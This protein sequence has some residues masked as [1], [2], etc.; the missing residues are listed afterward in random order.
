MAEFGEPRL[1]S[2]VRLVR[3]VDQHG[4]PR[5]LWNEG[6]QELELLPDETFGHHCREPAHIATRMR[7][8]L[9]EADRDRV[10]HSDENERNCR[11]TDVDRDRVWRS[12]SDDDLWAKRD[13][14]SH[15][16]WDLLVPALRVTILDLEIST[17]DIAAVA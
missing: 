5:R 1:I 10:A 4:D 17:H 12:V 8:A 11:S 6:L 14:L 7:Q 13:E 15:E 3:G 9:H 16:R 2:P